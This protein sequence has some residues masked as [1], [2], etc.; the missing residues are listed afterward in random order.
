M[1]ARIEGR[2]VRD[3]DRRL[4]DLAKIE[5]A[6]KQR[7]Y[8]EVRRGPL[9]SSY[10]SSPC[11][12]IS[13]RMSCQIGSSLESPGSR[14]SFLMINLKLYLGTGSSESSA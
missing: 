9:V 7:A 14:T 1:L 13:P 12:A 4:K 5:R 10:R 2:S 6:E 3:I 8:M 11:I